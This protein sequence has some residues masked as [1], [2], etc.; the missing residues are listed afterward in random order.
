M[1]KVLIVGQPMH[2]VLAHKGRLRASRDELFEALCTEQFSA[3]HRFV[4]D[5]IMQHIEACRNARPS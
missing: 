2:Q 4:A 3:A 5:E 1:I